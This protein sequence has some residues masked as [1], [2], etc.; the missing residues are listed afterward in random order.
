MTT[1]HKALR[2]KQ[3]THPSVSNLDASVRHI[4]GI[5]RPL[6]KTSCELTPLKVQRPKAPGGST[7]NQNEKLAAGRA[8][9]ATEASSSREGPGS[10]KRAWV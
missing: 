3:C 6:P 5:A 9:T 10:G 4:I 7:P 2:G 8:P 1:K